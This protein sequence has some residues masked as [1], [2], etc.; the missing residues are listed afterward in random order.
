[1]DKQVHQAAASDAL[2]VDTDLVAHEEV[3]ARV[4]QMTRML[5]D[6]LRGLGF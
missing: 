1:V 5:H 6:N 3:L 2:L 4:G